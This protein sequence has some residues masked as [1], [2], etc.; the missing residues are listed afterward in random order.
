[1]T[2]LPMQ[3]IVKQATENNINIVSVAFGSY[4]DIAYLQDIAQYSG[5]NLYHIYRP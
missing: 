3:A 1:M 2:A 4:L 5:G